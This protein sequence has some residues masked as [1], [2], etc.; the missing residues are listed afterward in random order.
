MTL[1]FSWAEWARLRALEIAELVRR[2]AVTRDEVAAQAAAAVR[3]VDPLLAAAVE[4]RDQPHAPGDID[5]PAAAYQ[6]LLAG[7]PLY[8][9][10]L[11]SSAA[12]LARELGSSLHEGELTARTDPLVAAWLREGASLL[13]RTTTAELGM[14]YD[15]STSYGGLRVTR[16]PWDPRRTAGGSS[17]GAAALVAAGAL[18]AAHAT[19]GAGS[20][21][22][23][24]AF[25]ACVGLKLTRGRLPP[26]WGV[27]ELANSTFGE[28]VISRTLEDSAL[29]LDAATRSPAPLGSHYVALPHDP[30]RALTSLAE[31][32]PRPLRVGV[33]THAFGRGAAPDP[34][35]L[36]VV[37]RAADA[38]S[39]AGH[40]VEPIAEGSLPDWAPLYRRFETL[41]AGIRAGSWRLR[42]GELSQEALQR[43][44]PMVRGFWQR[45]ER[46]GK[47]E[48]LRYLAGNAETTLR[49][50]QLLERYDVLLLP[51]FPVA[52]PDANTSLSTCV[53]QD[54]EEFLQRFLDAGRY[55]IP[56]NEAGLPALALPIAFDDAALPLAVQLYGRWRGEAE[57][58]RAGRALE[59]LLPLPARIPTVHVTHGP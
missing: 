24:A 41:W 36:A 4:I 14:A 7:V 30:S 27:N 11:G 23:P 48:L 5:L 28:G 16:N 49:F 47:P 22:V 39:N 45:S 55:T 9:K 51:A 59:Q 18:P 21:R 37:T 19:D 3:R 44:S 56:A 42:H 50:A 54:F 12:G 40:V 58:L 38:L 43:L 53:E 25:T 8:L 57:L 10:D 2:G 20:I 46:Y 29:F 35:R 26:Q 32:L 6:G 1:A 13:G 15:T 31:P 34:Q 33:T 52:P 17:G